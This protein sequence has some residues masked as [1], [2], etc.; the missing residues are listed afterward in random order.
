MTI[1]TTTL[2]T[3][4][5]DELK[6]AHFAAQDELASVKRAYMQQQGKTYEDLQRAAAL[7]VELRCE[8]ERRM[9]GKVKLNRRQTIASLM[10]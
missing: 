10:R 3:M 4:P 2:S 5:K 1:D 8:L 9:F 6:A 7:V